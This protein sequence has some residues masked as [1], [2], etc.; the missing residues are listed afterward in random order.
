MKWIKIIIALLV[1]AAVAVVA[2]R[3]FAP[4]DSMPEYKTRAAR[5]KNVEQMVELCTADVHEE[6]AV[7]DSIN[8]MWVVARQTIDGRVRFDLDSLRTEQRGDTTVVYLPA[9]RVDIL[10]S[11]D[12]GAY[13]ILDVWDGRN[14][15]FKRTLT[16]AEENVLKT[17]WQKRARNRIYQRGYVREARSNAVKSLTPLLGAMHGNGETI[18][19][20]D[21]TPNGN[22]QAR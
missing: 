20:V 13:E 3:F 12:P 16:A 2:V 18:V 22:P 9:E 17:R 6:W 10:E 8:G 11:T 15:L 4:S 1:V 5:I 7:K 21:P 14:V 19:I